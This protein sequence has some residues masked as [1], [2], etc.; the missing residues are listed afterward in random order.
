MRFKLFPCLICLLL[1]SALLTTAQA[2]T[3]AKNWSKYR[4]AVM[5]VLKGHISAISLVA[6]N[7]VEDTGHLKQH[8]AGLA[9]AATEVGKIFPA[10]SG[11]G[12]H[13]LP[14]IWEQ[15]EEFA[16]AVAEL[17]RT[18]QA[19]SEAIAGGDRRTIASAFKAAG[20][21]CKGCHEKFREEHDHD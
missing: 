9:E 19:L 3:S 16:A 4:H 18:T 20:D 17:E 6:F 7:Q 15:P 8:A 2:E 14:A 12:T 5:D 13:A 11:E 1:A 21:A 10:G